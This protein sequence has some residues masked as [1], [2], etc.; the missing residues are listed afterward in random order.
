MS[1]PSTHRP[2]RR[3]GLYP[4]LGAVLRKDVTT[5]LSELTITRAY[6]QLLFVSPN[7]D[8]SKSISL[9][10]AGQ[11]EVLLIEFARPWLADSPPVWLELYA[12]D[13]DAAIDSCCCYDFEEM[14]GAAR[15]LIVRAKELSDQSQAASGPKVP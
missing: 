9:A 10:R 7:Q 12:H 4:Q 6:M 14:V 15:H 3:A 11:Y 2:V 1:R 5:P 8:G 13:I